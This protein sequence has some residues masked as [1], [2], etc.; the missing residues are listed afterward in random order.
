MLKSLR[1]RRFLGLAV[2]ILGVAALAFAANPPPGAC[3]TNDAAWTTANGG[4]Q[5]QTSG[6]VWSS[7][8]NRSLMYNGPWA[9]AVT[10]CDNLVEGGYSDWRLPT[11]NECIQAAHDGAWEWEGDPPH[12]QNF[13]PREVPP[14]YGP[15]WTSKYKANNAYLFFPEQETYSLW[16]KKSQFGWYCVR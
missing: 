16:S 1:I 3:L 4:C 11:L 10:D 13:D 2:A 5:D 6:L 9:Y 7:L 14:R 8:R 12:L 15:I